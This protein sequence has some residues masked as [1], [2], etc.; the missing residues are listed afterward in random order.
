MAE[1]EFRGW[2]I[3]EVVLNPGGNRVMVP[4]EA[5]CLAVFDRLGRMYAH[6]RC[7]PRAHRGQERLLAVV[8]A[9]QIVPAPEGGEHVGTLVMATGGGKV[10]H[11]FE[12]VA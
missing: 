3:M 8:G 7:D 9:D 10:W 4:A 5:Q 11:V 2:G 1:M 12:H 6:Y